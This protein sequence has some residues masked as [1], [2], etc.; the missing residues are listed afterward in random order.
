MTDFTGYLL[1]WDHDPRR[2][3]LLMGFNDMDVNDPV[4]LPAA[5]V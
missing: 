2:D 3:R 5:R 4:W 1:Y